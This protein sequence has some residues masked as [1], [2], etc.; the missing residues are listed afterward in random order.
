MRESLMYNFGIRAAAAKTK[1]KLWLLQQM[2]ERH[3]TDNL[4]N[5][6]DYT[7]SFPNLLKCHNREHLFRVTRIQ[8]PGRDLACFGR[9]LFALAGDAGSHLQTT[10]GS[11]QPRQRCGAFGTS[12]S[13]TFEPWQGQALYTET[14]LAI[15][16]TQ[17][18]F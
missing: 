11:T 9:T 1:P 14:T 13:D 16:K 2:A 18:D 5:Y 12:S 8:Q 4:V 15:L 3:S 6:S 17:R 10:A 7:K